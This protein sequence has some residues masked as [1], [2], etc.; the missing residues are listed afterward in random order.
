MNTKH[1]WFFSFDKKPDVSNTKELADDDSSSEITKQ[2]A[3]VLPLF[4]VSSQIGELFTKWLTGSGGGCKK[5]RAA[6]QVVKRCFNFFKF[7]CED[8][9]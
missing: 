6:Q 8:E 5:Y 4:S 1:S 9:E 3:R 2:T 7:C